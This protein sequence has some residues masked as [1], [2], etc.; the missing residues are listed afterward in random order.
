M[1]KNTIVTFHEPKNGTIEL[2]REMRHYM[3]KG[4]EYI[5]IFQQT[6]ENVLTYDLSKIEMKV[7]IFVLSQVGFDNN[8]VMPGLQEL[9]AKRINSYQP[10]ISKALKKLA[11]MKIL[12]KE[13]LPDTRSYRYRVNYSLCAKTKGENVKEN[14]SKDLRNNPIKKQRSLFDKED[15]RSDD[16]KGR[17]RKPSRSKI[18]NKT[19]EE[20]QE[21]TNAFCKGLIG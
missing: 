9:C 14:F 16:L 17:S 6:L 12:I 11:D 2:H 7:F 15:D 19:E 21:I 8:L 18:S 3:P 4:Y 13:S 20:R 10:D 1:S 5:L